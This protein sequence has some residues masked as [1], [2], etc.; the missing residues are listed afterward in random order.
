[1]FRWPGRVLHAA[2]DASNLQVSRADFAALCSYALRRGSSC[3]EPAPEPVAVP[4]PPAP[5]PVAVRQPDPA[6][7]GALL[8]VYSALRPSVLCAA[9]PAGGA[10]A[11]GEEL[12][13]RAADPAI[14]DQPVQAE[15]WTEA[16]LSVFRR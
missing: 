8:F 15:P 7:A 13:V 11:S 12:P 16:E 2:S 9:A 10:N 4:Q 14:E 6:A 5:G 3:S 1:M